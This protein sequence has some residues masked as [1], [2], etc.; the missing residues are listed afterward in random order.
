[1]YGGFSASVTVESP[2]RNSRGAD[3]GAAAM[4]IPAIAGSEPVNVSV[5]PGVP[6][7]PANQFC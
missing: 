4:P 2:A 7:R 3:S 5:S 6:G 1:V